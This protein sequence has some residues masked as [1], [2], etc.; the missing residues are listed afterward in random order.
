MKPQT[1]WPATLKG[2]EVA[3]KALVLGQQNFD[4]SSAIHADLERDLR[5]ETAD[6]EMALEAWTAATEG[7]AHSAAV[8]SQAEATAAEC[9]QRI[10]QARERLTEMANAE[11]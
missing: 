8:A 9:D 5:V 2:Y 7:A 1:Q 6:R 10:E 4:E 11:R 3:R